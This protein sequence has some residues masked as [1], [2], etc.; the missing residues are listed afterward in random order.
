MNKMIASIFVLG[1]LTATFAV[2]DIRLESQDGTLSVS[3]KLINFEDGN[4]TV[5]TV[6][7][8]ITVSSELVNCTGEECPELPEINQRIRIAASRLIAEA[9]IPAVIKQYAEN[10]DAALTQDTSEPGTATIMDNE[11]QVLATIETTELN[12]SEAFNA[13]LNGDLDLILTERRVSNVEIDAALETNLGDLSSDA[14][15]IIWALDGVSVVVSKANPVQTM[16][17]EQLELVFSGAI[18]NWAELGGPDLPVKVYLPADDPDLINYFTATILDRNFSTFTDNADLSLDSSALDADIAAEPGAIGLLSSS[19]VS[20]A[21]PL[22]LGS[23]CGLEYAADSFSFRSETY[24]L[25]RRLYAYTTSRST[26]SRLDELVALLQA[27]VG[28]DAAAQAGFAN[29][30]EELTDMNTFGKQLAYSLSSDEQASELSRLVDFANQLR[31]AK[32]LSTTFRFSS[33]SSQL[34]NKSRI[35]AVRLAQFLQQTE[36]QGAEIVLAGFSD[37]IGKSALNEVLSQRRAGQVKD[38]ILAVDGVQLDPES[39]TVAGYGAAF[40][41]ACN[42][43]ALGRQANRRVDVWIR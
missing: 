38:A 34:D 23:S 6:V 43:S 3:G 15:E 19:K 32:R 8:Q 27:S 40:P 20:T 42:D 29:F 18:S 12:A 11:D 16:T 5:D 9:F 17:L 26:S 14:R 2:A 22:I 30:S 39:I 24:P 4:Y 31:S 10:I 21:E 28:Q 25:T 35:D 36:Y 33:G 13:L 7:G 41:A 37:S 1:I